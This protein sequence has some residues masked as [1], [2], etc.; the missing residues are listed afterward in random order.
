MNKRSKKSKNMLN[1]PKKKLKTLQNKRR[2]KM[3]IATQ[4]SIFFLMFLKDFLSFF[5]FEVL[6]VRKNIKESRL[7]NI[8]FRCIF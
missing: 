4:M 7:K 3:A 8:F 2:M 5:V 6:I 1:I